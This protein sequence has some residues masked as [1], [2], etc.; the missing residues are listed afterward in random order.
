[1]HIISWNIRQRFD[2][3]LFRKGKQIECEVQDFSKGIKRASSLIGGSKRIWSS[4]ASAPDNL[5]QRFFQIDE[6]TLRIAYTAGLQGGGQDVSLP[7][8]AHNK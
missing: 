3:K 6:K 5:L 2:V 8:K 4:F 7:N 1:M